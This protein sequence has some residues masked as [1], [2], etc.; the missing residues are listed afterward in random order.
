MVG[1][2]RKLDRPSEGPNISVL[3]VVSLALAVIGTGVVWMVI[4]RALRISELGTLSAGTALRQRD[5]SG[6]ARKGITQCMAERSGQ[7]CINA[8]SHQGVTTMRKLTIAL[9]ASSPA[10]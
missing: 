8:P 2:L 4:F 7:T 10:K 3:L 9:A 5:F 6:T 1:Y